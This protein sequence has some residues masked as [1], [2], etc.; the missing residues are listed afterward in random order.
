[1][2]EIRK[3]QLIE[4]GLIP[5]ISSDANEEGEEKKGSIYARKRKAKKDKV[6][7][8]GK[9]KAADSLTAAAKN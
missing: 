6:Q 8:E 9:D 4:A 2:A 7:E 5:N 3:Q 1:M